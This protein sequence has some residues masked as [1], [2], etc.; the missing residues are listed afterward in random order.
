MIL[1]GRSVIAS[2]KQYFRKPRCY[3]LKNLEDE[4]IFPGWETD[5]DGDV[6]VVF[7]LVWAGL[8]FFVVVLVLIILSLFFFDQHLRL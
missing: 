1:N 5:E 7:V 2:P 4:A 3:G 6:P 8:F